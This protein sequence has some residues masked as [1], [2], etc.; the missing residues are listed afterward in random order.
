MRAGRL[1]LMHASRPL[2]LV[3]T[4][5]RLAWSRAWTESRRM[6]RGKIPGRET[7]IEVRK[8][9]CTICDPTTQCGLDCYVKDGRIIKVEGTARESAER[10]HAL[11]QGRR[12]AAV[13]LPRGPAAHAAQAGG[14]ARHRRR[15]SPSPGPRPSTPSP[16]TCR[17]IKA[18]SGPESVVFYC[19]YPKQPRPF[20]QRLAMLYGSPNYCTESSA[21]YTAAVMGWR[22]DLRP[23][24]RPRTSP[25]PSAC[26]SGAQSVPLRHP[27]SRGSSWTPASEA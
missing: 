16:R 21:C 18:E 11:R 6:T 26:S 12:S 10:G 27:Q 17:R 3:R 20:L 5:Y 19:G 2:L 13:G 23:D 15:W 24:G 8:S 1:A 22:S 25:T 9:I 7:G 4:R 14:P